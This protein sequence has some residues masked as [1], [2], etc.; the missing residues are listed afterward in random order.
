M[1]ENKVKKKIEHS[2]ITI[3]SILVTLGVEL[4]A[5]LMVSKFST[6]LYLQYPKAEFP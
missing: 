6:E 3:I 2:S 1:I 5:S 4:R